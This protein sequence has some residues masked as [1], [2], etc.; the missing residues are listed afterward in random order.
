[1]RC[2]Q[3]IP[4]LLAVIALLPGPHHVLAQ[5][6]TRLDSDTLI[7]QELAAG[8]AHHYAIALDSGWF[9]FIAVEQRGIDV[10]VRVRGPDGAPV[11]EVD[12]PNG[13]QGI[14]P[15]L[16]FTELSGDYRI[17]VSP[18]NA[19]AEPGRYTIGIERVEPVAATPAGR[20]DQL[21]A[22]WDRSGSPG[23]S[24]GIMQDGQITFAKGYGEAQLEYGIPITSETVF[25]VASVSK[26]FTAFGAILLADRGLLSLDD[27]IRT[28]LPEIHDFGPTITIRHLIHHTSGLR[29][30]WDLL[31]MGGWRLDDV[32]TRSQIMRILERQR[33]LNFDPGEEQLY[34]NS[35]YT[36]LAEIVSRVTGKPFPQFMREEVFEPLGMNRTHFHDDHEMVV[37]NRAY[38][39]G[40]APDGGFRT[41]V[42]SY[43]NVGATS[44]FT[45]VGDALQWM[46][47]LDRGAVGGSRVR[48]LMHER[49]VLNNGD[50][51]SYA[52]GLS[53]G[54][55]RGLRLIGHSGGD[56]GFRSYI[57]RFPDQG[58]AV[59]IFSNLGSFDPAAMARRVADVYLEGQFPPAPDA[60]IAE[61][62]GSVESDP[63]PPVFD[64]D[65][66]PL[67]AYTGRYYS[68]E[69][70]TAYSLVVA[71]GRLTAVHVRH[72]PMAFVPVGPDRFTLTG[73][74]VRFDR[75][76]DGAVVGMRISS[77]RVRNLRFDRVDW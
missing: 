67:D 60:L 37:P 42:L 8:E 5:D 20:V 76:A 18:L 68:P 75:D 72:D 49:G 3:S 14:E 25:H 40:S 13:T 23:V 27:D 10:I 52:A 29:D 30:Q 11:A 53:V 7:W 41:I 58:L 62:P 51:L 54:S 31:S 77:G 28:Y 45:T 21:F 64:P 56:A 26:Q 46:Q 15:V 57:G 36:L 59:A 6:V 4:R 35:G 63:R 34:C 69:L 50:T 61:A 2:P 1:M 17:E 24:I 12:S 38:S 22:V 44:L 16:L 70:E 73:S 39:Y 55:Y 71:G 47:N 74:Q 65:A 48:E 9:A 19:D 43:A 32:I 33:E 66:V